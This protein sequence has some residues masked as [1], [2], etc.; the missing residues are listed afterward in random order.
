MV[1][2]PLLSISITSYTIERLKDITELLDSIKAQTYS[3]IE[4]VFVAERSMELL[5]EVKRYGDENA[6][7]NVKVIFN[8][9][10]AGMSAA[11]NLGIREAKGDIIAF[12]DDDALLFPEWAEETVK[13]YEDNSTI[14][15]TGP[16]SP[17]WED[18]SMAWF[19][20]ELDWILGCSN[21]SGFSERREISNVYTVRRRGES[22]QSLD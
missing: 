2:K 4:I 12:V 1:D 18:E 5:S 20:D 13:T 11:R 3:N 7:A 6:I 15:V 19:P 16:I 17:L 14:A 9:G 8:H 22:L 10:E 21:F